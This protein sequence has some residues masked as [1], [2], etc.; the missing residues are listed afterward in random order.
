MAR[1]QPKHKYNETKM[2]SGMEEV[3]LTWSH[4]VE[5]E[6]SWRPVSQR[7]SGVERA[8]GRA[9]YGDMLGV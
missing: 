6:F 4:F 8:M 2:V 3:Q 5:F 1:H 9:G 7:V